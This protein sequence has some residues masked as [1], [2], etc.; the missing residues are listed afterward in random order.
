MVFSHMYLAFDSVQTLH[1][2]LHTANKV[3]VDLH[4]ASCALFNVPN[5]YFCETVRATMA[6]LSEPL[7]DPSFSTKL[8]RTLH[9][10]FAEKLVVKKNPQ[11]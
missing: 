6:R 3:G 5:L 9:Y 2:M 4:H 10:P 1:E 7:N 8:S 11:L